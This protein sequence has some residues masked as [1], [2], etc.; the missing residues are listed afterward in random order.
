MVKKARA[1]SVALTNALRA[2]TDKVTGRS[3]LPPVAG[4]LADILLP[5]AN[6]RLCMSLAGE[7]LEGDVRAPVR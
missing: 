2:E 7:Y 4:T 1:I 6:R 5:Q 3:A